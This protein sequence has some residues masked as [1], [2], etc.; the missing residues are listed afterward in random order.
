M[1]PAISPMQLSKFAPGFRLSFI[2][3]VVLIAGT[4]G[5]LALWPMTWWWGFVLGFVLVHFF[6]FCNVFR[7][8]RPLELA[9]AGVFVSLAAATIALETPGWLTTVVISLC[10]TI[11][12]VLVEM[13]KP[14]YHGIG[15]QK[16]NPGL[17][18][19]WEAHTSGMGEFS[20]K[21]KSE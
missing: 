21:M 19:W 3:C 16:I 18:V 20:N 7:L 4:I 12:V 14:S 10:T 1:L 6:L 9:W 15:W 2:D 11:F 8:T 17:P 5:T 13:R